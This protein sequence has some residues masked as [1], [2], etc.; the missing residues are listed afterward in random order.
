MDFE[1]FAPP[2]KLEKNQLKMQHTHMKGVN[3]VEMKKMH[4]EVKHYDE[5]VDPVEVMKH[6]A[7]MAAQVPEMD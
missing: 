3:E 1:Q 5:V 4:Q 2:P 7:Q 6:K